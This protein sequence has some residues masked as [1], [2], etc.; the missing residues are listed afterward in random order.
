M[1]KDDD[2]NNDNDEAMDCSFACLSACEC[3][4]QR[5]IVCVCVLHSLFFPYFFCRCDQSKCGACVSLYKERD[6]KK[7]REKESERQGQWT[8]VSMLALRSDNGVHISINDH[9]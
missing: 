6:N 1:F 8:C 4:C 9:R 3:E 5:V 7:E 2:N